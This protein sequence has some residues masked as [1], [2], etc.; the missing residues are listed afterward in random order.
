MK[1]FRVSLWRR[2]QQY[3]AALILSY[4]ACFTLEKKTFDGGIIIQL[5]K[6]LQV[7]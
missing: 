1:K 2:R 3:V 5:L 7:L 6:P 4:K